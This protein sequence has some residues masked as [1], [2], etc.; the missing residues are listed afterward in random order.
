MLVLTLDVPVRTTRSRE[1][2]GGIV[3]PF[4]ITPSM[5]MGVATS[6]SYAAAL[7]KHGI[8]RFA[9]LTPYAGG[10][11]SPNGM[12]KFMRGEQRGAFNW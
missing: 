5:A 10:D 11:T 6:P 1:M 9:C 4:R 12:G 2:A 7:M 8:T 3:Y